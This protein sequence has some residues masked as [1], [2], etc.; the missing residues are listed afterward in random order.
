MGARAACK[1]LMSDQRCEVGG[2]G[3]EGQENGNEPGCF[4]RG[5]NHG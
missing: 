3:V 1:A 5:I 2:G 4:D